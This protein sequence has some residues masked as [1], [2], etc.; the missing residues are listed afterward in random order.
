[1]RL[2]DHMRLDICL[3]RTQD[4]RNLGT[5]KEKGEWAILARL[6]LSAG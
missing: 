3:S 4:L 6:T 1:M 5:N 2:V